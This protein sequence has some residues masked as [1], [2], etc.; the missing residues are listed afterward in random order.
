MTYNG[1]KKGE[2]ESYWDLMRRAGLKALKYRETKKKFKIETPK[3][4]WEFA[5]DYF[6]YMDKNPWQK[7]DFIKGGEMAGSKVHLNTARPYTWKGFSAFLITKGIS[8]DLSEYRANTRGIYDEF[9]AVVA[10]I[11]SIMY[12][13][14][15]EGAA[16]G[17]FNAGL[18]KADL[19]I[20]DVVENKVVEKVENDID[21]SKLSDSALEEILAQKVD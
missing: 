20:A 5:C 6:E 17:A 4:L 15:F 2:D 11:D 14:K 12:A 18:I 3:L 9:R 10:T 1:I 19:K 21:Y 13:Q 7:E 16:V 8:T